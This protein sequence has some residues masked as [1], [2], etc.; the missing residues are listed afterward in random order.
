[1]IAAE[2]RKYNPESANQVSER[3]RNEANVDDAVC[4]WIKVYGEARNEHALDHVDR[5]EELNAVLNYLVDWNF[6]SGV[7]WEYARFQGSL[8]W[9]KPGSRLHRSLERG[10]LRR[11]FRK[12]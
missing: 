4:E 3:V 11:L 6:G 5:N 8:R 2:I 10:L 12:T 7:A 1:L 9:P